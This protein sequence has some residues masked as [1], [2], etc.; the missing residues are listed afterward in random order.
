LHVIKKLF[1]GRLPFKF[2]N[3]QLRALFSKAGEVQSAVMVPDTKNGQ[4]R[5]FGFV[6]MSS[7]LEAQQAIDTLNGTPLEDKKIWVTI[8][9]EKGES[10]RPERTPFKSFKREDGP[11]HRPRFDEN[12]FSP[13]ARPSR[14]SFRGRRPF[15]GSGSSEVYGG[16]GDGRPTRPVDGR[17]PFRGKRPFPGSASSEPFRGGHDRR[18]ARPTDGRP[19]R[20]P[21][22]SSG[23]RPPPRAADGRPSQGPKRD[24][25]PKGKFRGSRPG[26]R[27]PSSGF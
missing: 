13:S 25:R 21:F 10:Q 5:G 17:T 1:V 19:T 16:G 8:A 24:F 22:R 9:R 14:P 7:E 2:T 27:R 18:P 20:T 26:N 12:R 4:T 6:E 15:P 23:D 11:R 3:E